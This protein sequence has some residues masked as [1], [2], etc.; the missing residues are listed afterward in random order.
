MAQRPAHGF[1]ATTA[2]L[3]AVVRNN[4]LWHLAGDSGRAAHSRESAAPRL[5][6]LPRLFHSKANSVRDGRIPE[7]KLSARRPEL[8]PNRQQIRR[9]FVQKALRR[10]RCGLH[11]RLSFQ[12]RAKSRPRLRFYQ[13][14]RRRLC[15]K[16]MAVPHAHLSNPSNQRFSD[17]GGTDSAGNKLDYIRNDQGADRQFEYFVPD[18]ANGLTPAGLARLNQSIEAFVYCILGAQVNVRSSILGRR[19]CGGGERPSKGIAER[20]SRSPGGRDPNA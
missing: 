6:S 5:L 10:I 20:I 16:A 13:L 4:R 7:N 8:Q 3:R 2:K 18:S 11:R 15:A 17:E 14:Q 19:G 9:G 1:L 12:P